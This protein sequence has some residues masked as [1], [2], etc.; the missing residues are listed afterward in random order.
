MA[1]MTIAE[2]ADRTLEHLGIK[3]AGQNASAEDAQRVIEIVTSVLS[4]LRYENL[5]PFEVTAIP[6]YAQLSV[7]DISAAEC[8]SLYGLS[9]ERLQV[10]LQGREMARLDLSRQT[11]AKKPPIAVRPFWF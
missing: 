1:T 7:R 3:P 8:A 6:E 5:A 2:I 11:A 10:V 9:G 4:K